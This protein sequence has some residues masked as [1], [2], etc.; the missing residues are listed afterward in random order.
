M[1]KDDGLL[2]TRAL[3]AFADIANSLMVGVDHSGN[4]SQSSSPLFTGCGCSK[5]P[6]YNLCPNRELIRR[7]RGPYV[8]AKLV[9]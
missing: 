2:V 3:K 1:M 6:V 7:Y 5:A 4:E 8:T 9:P